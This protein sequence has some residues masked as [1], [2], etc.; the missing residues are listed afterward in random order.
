MTVVDSVAA[1]RL[2]E[3]S[4]RLAGDHRVAHVRYLNSLAGWLAHCC[5]GLDVVWVRHRSATRRSAVH[6]RAHLGVTA[7]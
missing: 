7:V 1:V 3:E 5:I 4:G 2:D 6:R